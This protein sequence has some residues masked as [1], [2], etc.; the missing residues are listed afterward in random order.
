MNIFD[1]LSPLK[2]CVL[3][4]AIIALVFVLYLLYIDKR[5]RIFNLLWLWLILNEITRMGLLVY[6]YNRPPL[7]AL[8][9]GEMLI[10]SNY[11]YVIRLYVLIVIIY[12]FI[13]DI[14]DIKIN[15]IV[16]DS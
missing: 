7:L 12:K 13:I 15:S 10:I 2:F 5:K 9:S 4:V 8:D 1:V 14:R 3:M 11:S 16:E 6:F